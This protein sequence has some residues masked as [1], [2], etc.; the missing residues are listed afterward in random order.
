MVSTHLSTFQNLAVQKIE[1]NTGIS[2]YPNP[3]VGDLTIVSD[4]GLPY[5]YALMSSAGV[6]VI[7]GNG[8]GKT[9]IDGS[10]L[11]AGIYFIR[12][13]QNGIT[14]VSQVVKL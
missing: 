2:V 3:T 10:K 6:E 9:L 5:T 1:N 11:A 7:S 4:N 12:I 8:S 13:E 14:L